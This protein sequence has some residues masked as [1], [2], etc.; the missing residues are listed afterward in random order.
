MKHS[1]AD[2]RET[3][4]QYYPRGLAT[5]DP[6]YTKTKEYCRLSDARRRAGVEKQKWNALL[7]RADARFP[8]TVAVNRSLHL[9]TGMM[10][11]AYSG[12]MFLEVPPPIAARRPAR[13]WEHSPGPPTVGFLISFICP[14]YVIYVSRYVDDIEETEAVLRA[15]RREAVDIY[16]GDTMYVVPASVVKPE[17]RAAAE[18]EDQELRQHLQQHPLQRRVIAFDPSPDEKPYMDWLARDIEATFGCEPIPRRSGT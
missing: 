16:A 6:G 17:I 15:P 14:C 3:V 12:D 10:D 1:V 4:Y 9:P 5:D 8:G 13:W 18:R 11:A 2:L 7:R